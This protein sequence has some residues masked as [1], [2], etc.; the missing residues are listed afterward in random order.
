MAITVDITAYGASLTSLIM[1]RFL[2]GLAA[3]FMT[4][5]YSWQGMF[6]LKRDAPE[7][8]VIVDTTNHAASNQP[9]YPHHE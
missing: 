1:L 7:I 6:V 8:E 2:S 4:P 5:D 9:F 3:G